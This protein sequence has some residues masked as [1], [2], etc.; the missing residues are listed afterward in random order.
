MI[1]NYASKFALITTL[2]SLLAQAQVPETFTRAD[3]SLVGPVKSCVV[4]ANYGEET[5]EFDRVGKLIKSETR[6]SDTDYDITY[7]RYRDS[8]LKERRDEVYRDR[9]FDEQTSIAHFYQRDTTGPPRLMERIV[10][11][12]RT[13]QEQ[14]VYYF[15]D[16]GRLSRIVRSDAEGVDETTVEYTVFKEEETASYYQ[17]GDLK[18]SVRTSRRQGPAGVQTTELTKEFVQGEPVKAVERTMDA[19]NRLIREVTFAFDRDKGS[20]V[21]SRTIDFTYNPQNFTES[22]TIVTHSANKGDAATAKKETRN[23]V[24]QMD[25]H[26]PG[27]WIRQIITPQNTMV[28]RQ[29]EY[30]QPQPEKAAKDSLPD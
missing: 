21:P 8:L 5:F 3:F 27:N 19:G 7:Y 29:I 24:Y 26:K 12:D 14:V 15:G 16:A 4:K 1:P 23:F 11:Y 20:F 18:K 25:G 10:S 2:F 28:V 17:N 22:E 30:Y 13:F 9:V 6:Y